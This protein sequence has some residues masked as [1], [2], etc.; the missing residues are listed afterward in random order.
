[1]ILRD[2]KHMR[3]QGERLFK[4]KWM[5]KPWDTALRIVEA[6]ESYLPGPLEKRRLF[7]ASEE[8]NKSYVTL[9]PIGTIERYT[10]SSCNFL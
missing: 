8:D 2:T 10:C 6:R 1:M 9:N 7:L 4:G 5:Y 3:A